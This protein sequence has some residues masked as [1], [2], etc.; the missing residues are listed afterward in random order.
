YTT[1]V[2]R[3]IKVGRLSFMSFNVTLSTLGTITGNVQIEGFPFANETLTGGA[4]RQPLYWASLT[5]TWVNMLCQM[6][7]AAQVCSVIGAASAATTTA[8][9][10]VQ[11]DLGATTNFGGFMLVRSAN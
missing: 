6:A 10:L 5:T 4:Q 1:Q 9:A 7:S 2:G 8:T 11:S 3:Y